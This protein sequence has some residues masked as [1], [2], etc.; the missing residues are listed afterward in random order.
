MA[1]Y[2]MC[3]PDS[4]EQAGLAGWDLGL[5][6]DLLTSG[7]RLVRKNSKLLNLVELALLVELAGVLEL[8][9][10]LRGSRGY[11]QG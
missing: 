11:Y 5:L 3:F 6:A 1:K 2:K 4:E 10:L 9:N 8:A 7:C